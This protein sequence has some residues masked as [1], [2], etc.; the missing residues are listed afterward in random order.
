MKEK[1][2]LRFFPFSWL[3]FVTLLCSLLG[4]TQ[5][6][7]DS[8]NILANQLQVNTAL[9]AVNI[10]LSKG[11]CATALSSISTIYS[12]VNTSNAVRLAIASAYACSAGVNVLSNLN[13][14]VNFQDSLAGAGFF[15]FLVSEFKSVTNPDD[16]KPTSAALAVDALLATVNSGTVFAPTYT[17]NSGTQNPGSLLVN[18][19]TG[20]SNAY[21]LFVAM[22]Q[23][24][25]LLYR[26]A[27]PLSNN[28]KSQN[29]AWDTPATSVGDGC[30]FSSA[31]LNFYD[32]LQYI[33]QGAPASAQKVYDT[34][35][36]FLQTS[37]NAACS[38][39]CSHNGCTMGCSS[40]PTTLRNRNS[41]TGQAT[42]ANS[43][44]SA[45]I[46]NFV[47][48]TWSGPP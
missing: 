27:S 26:D 41:C 4:C 45:G 37:L 28:H 23:M 8:A 29:L 44:A 18:D 15:Y 6:G 43:C 32:S 16:K 47:N 22:A 46:A 14:L 11:D 19:R 7:F 25:I 35:S 42:D 5:A 34:I 13:N 38:Y 2:R 17:V 31:I 48:T 1:R 30:A 20:D 39:G 21:L 24:G 9:D 33:D 40:C 36:V 3:G 12:S 10:A